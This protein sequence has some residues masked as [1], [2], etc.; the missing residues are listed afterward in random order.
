MRIISGVVRS[1]TL[2]LVSG[3]WWAASSWAQ[4]PADRERASIYFGAFI[5]DPATEV[6]LDSD[7]GEGTDIDIEDDLGVESSISVLRLG[8]YWWFKRRSRLDFSVFNV[9]RNGSKQIDKTIEFGD[10]TFTIDTV[11]STE[12]DLNVTKAAYTFAPLLKDRGYLGV[13]AGLHV[14]KNK[15][16]LSEPAL[17]AIESETLTAP[18]P[19]IGVRGQYA[20]TERFTL[21]GAVEVFGLETDDIDGSFADRYVAVDYSVGP[22]FDVGLAY[23]DVLF[24]ISANKGG[25][26]F[27]GTLDWGYTGWLLYMNVNF[28]KQQ[29]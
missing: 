21:R 24:D 6:R 7:S 22:R 14:T 15:L 27:N 9:G 10:R 19:V 5:T 12:T 26:R 20:F 17:G 1:V 8:G 4:E 25:N 2:V 3:S 28:G 11:V 13:T 23:N 18:L 29:P 16:S